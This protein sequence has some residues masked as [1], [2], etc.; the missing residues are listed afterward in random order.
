MDPKQNGA[1]PI[2]PIPSSPTPLVD[3][4][5][6]PALTLSDIYQKYGGK[7]LVHARYMD[8]LRG[9]QAL[10]PEEMKFFGHHAEAGMLQALAMDR[11]ASCLE[12]LAHASQESGKRVV[13]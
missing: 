3:A 11:I 13:V 9:H 12:R 7:L 10:L 2:T 4:A 5:T 6:R 1:D 8:T